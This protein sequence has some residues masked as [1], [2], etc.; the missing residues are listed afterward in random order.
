MDKVNP[1]SVLLSAA[2]MLTYMSWHEA[3]DAITEAL[4]RTIQQKKVTYDLARGIEKAEELSTSQFAAAIIA[5][6]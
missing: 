5:N 4:T 6:L 2:M 1:G 3:A